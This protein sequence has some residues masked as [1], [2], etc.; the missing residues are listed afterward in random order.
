MGDF[1]RKRSLS[2]RL[3]LGILIGSSI[4]TFCFSVVTLYWDYRTE[5]RQIE[6]TLDQ[7][8]S[9]YLES[10]SQNLWNMNDESIKLNLQSITS[11]GDI[12]YAH[13]LIQDKIVYSS[14]DKLPPS[15]QQKKIFSINYHRDGRNYHLGDLVVSA[16]LGGAYTRLQEEVLYE[17]ATSFCK[18]LILLL[19]ILAFFHKL[20][21]RHL[22]HIAHYLSEFSPSTKDLALFRRPGISDEL[23]MV[24]NAISRMKHEINDQLSKRLEAEE[25]L[26]ALNISLEAEVKK[27]IKE[28]ELQQMA[29]ESTARLSSLGEMA[30]GVAHEINNPLTIIYG[31]VTML[32]KAV[33]NN[34]L[35][36]AKI[37]LIVEKIEVTVDRITQ[38]IEGL[39]RLAQN[40]C[41]SP[42]QVH[43]LSL[44]IRDIL[45]ISREKFTRS[46]IEIKLDIPDYEIKA[47]CQPAEIG[48]ILIN[49]LNNAYY[50]IKDRGSPWVKI[51]LKDTPDNMAEI[52]II[53]SGPGIETKI[54][55]KILK[56][57]FTTKPPGKGAGLGLSISQAIAQGHHGQLY[58]DESSKH[59]RFVLALPADISAIHSPHSL[60][61]QL[62]FH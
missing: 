38:T 25:Q 8:Q 54:R 40:Q 16:D 53:D 13:I 2:Y 62:S 51:T 19:F 50:E 7:V 5:L 10:I 61:N 30:G 59:T 42:P 9:L 33:D 21:T 44:I 58:L 49:L 15:N 39:L 47:P 32:R 3:S 27:R 37:D 35:S 41:E 11:L 57:F 20:V 1:L 29:I 34:S 17:F 45:A 24:V 18:T 36:P 4:I 6:Q 26:K 28:N 55:S 22:I 43:S 23:T 31:Y 12:N 60:S 56:P 46:G 48:Q 52:A 14:G